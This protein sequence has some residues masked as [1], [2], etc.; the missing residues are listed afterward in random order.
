MAVGIRLRW[1]SAHT[2]EQGDTTSTSIMWTEPMNHGSPASLVTIA[3]RPGHPAARRWRSLATAM[4]IGISL[5]S[6]STGLENTP[7][8]LP[9]RTR[10]SR[11]GAGSL[12]FHKRFNSGSQQ[13]C[14]SWLW[15]NPSLVLLLHKNLGPMISLIGSSNEAYVYYSRYINPILVSPGDCL[16]YE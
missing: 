7:W 5:Q 2:N 9:L 4:V 14:G 3:I 16:F 1:A 13:P 12:D 15:S 6:T 10:L 8:P 11:V